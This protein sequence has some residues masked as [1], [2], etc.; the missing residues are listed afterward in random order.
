MSFTSLSIFNFYIFIIIQFWLASVMKGIDC[1]SVPR[2]SLSLSFEKLDNDVHRKI[3]NANVQFT[4][5]IVEQ[6][7]FVT[8][9]H[10]AYCKGSSGN[11]QRPM[12]KDFR[13]NEPRTRRQNRIRV[14]QQAAMPNCTLLALPF[15]LLPKWKSSEKKKRRGRFDLPRRWKWRSTKTGRCESAGVQRKASLGVSLFYPVFHNM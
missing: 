2:K 8:R 10:Q 15:P 14:S 6:S 12:S 9:R 11:S 4:R 1:A 7:T 5:W 3:E 13:S